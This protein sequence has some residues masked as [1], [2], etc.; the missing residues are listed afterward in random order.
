MSR[1]RYPMKPSRAAKIAR[2]AR[3]DEDPAHDTAAR[4]ETIKTL[5][6]LSTEIDFDLLDAEIADA[7]ARRRD[8]GIARPRAL[9]E[10]AAQRRVL[11]R[12]PRGLPRVAPSRDDEADFAAAAVQRGCR[13][14][15]DA[16]AM[17]RQDVM[18]T[19]KVGGVAASDDRVILTRLF[20]FLSAPAAISMA[21]RCRTSLS[22]SGSSSL[23]PYGR[24]TR[25]T[26]GARPSCIIRPRGRCP[27]PRT[28]L[29]R[30]AQ[31]QQRRRVCECDDP[32][33][34]DE[35]H[36]SRQIAPC[37]YPRDPR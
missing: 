35:A 34:G 11:R 19:D 10:A 25:T 3:A 37:R 32:E 36:W 20:A 16:G 33:C 8:G 13:R 27:S 26:S 18:T 5:R 23:S 12:L 17:R 21:P 22:R 6:T 31:H 24:A 9:C 30:P 4:A 2:G 7:R 15:D 14:R 29:G 28:A 1:T